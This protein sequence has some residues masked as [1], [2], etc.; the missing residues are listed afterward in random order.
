MNL[1]HPDPLGR[2]GKSDI[3]RFLEYYG[4]PITE[5]YDTSLTS[6]VKKASVVYGSMFGFGYFEAYMRGATVLQRYHAGLV[7][8]SRYSGARMAFSSSIMPVT[9]AL[10]THRELGKTMTDNI[11]MQEIPGSRGGYTNP[12]GGSDDNEFYYPFKGTIDYIFG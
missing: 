8:A 9:A 3:V 1:W 4:S 5:F 10:L 11:G 2:R 12:M 6:M 7:A